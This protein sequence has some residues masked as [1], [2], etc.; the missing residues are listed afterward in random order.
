MKH[1]RL[2]AISDQMI[3]ERLESADF[4]AV[5]ARSSS[6]SDLE[7]QLLSDINHEPI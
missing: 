4:S 2:I 6:S 1:F 3:M 7:E 5:L